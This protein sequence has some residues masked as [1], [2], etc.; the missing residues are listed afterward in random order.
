MLTLTT[1]NSKTLE[2][3]APEMLP[4]AGGS[5]RQTWLL[6]IVQSAR[7]VSKYGIPNPQIWD[8]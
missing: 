7:N 3:T 1:K 8:R 5:D 2:S 4:G 6:N